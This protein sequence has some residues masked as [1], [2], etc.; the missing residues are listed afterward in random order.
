[1]VLCSIST[2]S[3]GETGPSIYTGQVREFPFFHKSNTCD[4]SMYNDGKE[5]QMHQIFHGR[6]CLE[7]ETT[8]LTLENFNVKTHQKKMEK[9]LL[10]C[11]S[12]I[13]A[14]SLPSVHY[15]TITRGMTISSE[16][17]N[18]NFLGSNFLLLRSYSQ[19]KWES[20]IPGSTGCRNFDL[21]YQPTPNIWGYLCSYLPII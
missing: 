20:R 17:I 4:I 19:Q 16:K 8:E 3:A 10:W 6:T 14:S 7:I 21:R 1:M 5:V 11:M 18:L 2:N 12:P 9:M 13:M 15:T